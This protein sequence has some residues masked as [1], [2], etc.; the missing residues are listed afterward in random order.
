[1]FFHDKRLQFKVKAEEPDALLAA[2]CQELIG[3]V[4]GEMTVANQ[5]LFQGWNCRGPAKYKDML[6]DIGTEELAHIEMLATLVS[7]LVA[8][9]PLA[10]QEAAADSSAAVAAVMGGMNPQH[11]IVTGGGAAPADSTGFPWQGRY[12]TASGNLLA[13]FR[14]NLSAESNGR[15]QAIRVYNM[16]DDPGVKETLRFLIARDTMHQNQWIAAIEDLQAE[17]YDTTPVPGGF[18]LDEEMRSVSYQF[19]DLSKPGTESSQGRWASG[20]APD[21]KGTFEYLE[22]PQ[23]LGEV[24]PPPASDPR[25]Y[26]TTQ[27]PPQQVAVQQPTA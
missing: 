11:A 16:T 21:G 2:K 8:G 9:A 18:P 4:Y 26:D 6:L 7:Q 23:P 20:P 22:N 24:P 13:D 17:G 19:W 10:T 12:V 14:S 25:L 15:L 1:M 3:G 27:V 5:Y